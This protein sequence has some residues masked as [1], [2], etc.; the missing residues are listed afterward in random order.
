MGTDRRLDAKYEKQEDTERNIKETLEK[1][2]KEEDEADEARTL[3]D[4]M[5]QSVDEA[6]AK[7]TGTRRRLYRE[8]NEY[9]HSWDQELGRPHYIIG[10]VWQMIQSNDTKTMN[11]NKDFEELMSKAQH[12]G[13]NG[14]TKTR[15]FFALRSNSQMESVMNSVAEWFSLEEVKVLQGVSVLTSVWAREW[16]HDID[17]LMWE[18]LPEDWQKYMPVGGESPAL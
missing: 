16:Q 10:K 4:G 15:R 3:L 5:Q 2:R 6:N 11:L 14:S 12:T 1:L 9:M 17:G 7:V 18:D 13:W 8:I